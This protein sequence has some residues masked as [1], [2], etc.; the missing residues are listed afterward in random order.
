MVV[1]LVIVLPSFVKMAP[2]TRKK[3]CNDNVYIRKIFGNKTT[4]IQRVIISCVF[5]RSRFTLS[6]AEVATAA[7]T[8]ATI[9]TGYYPAH[10]EEG[11]QQNNNNYNLSRFDCLWFVK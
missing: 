8:T 9:T 4:Y 2:T 6:T 7:Q 5:G 3:S 1:R 11:L 10:D